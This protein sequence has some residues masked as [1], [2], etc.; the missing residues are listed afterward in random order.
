MCLSGEP[1]ARA[2]RIDYPGVFCQVACGGTCKRR[3]ETGSTNISVFAKKV[4]EPFRSNVVCRGKEMIEA[5][6]PGFFHHTRIRSPGCSHGITSLPWRRIGYGDKGRNKSRHH[7]GDYRFDRCSAAGF[8][9]SAGATAQ[10][11][12]NQSIDS[13]L[14]FDGGPIG[15]DPARRREIHK[16][17]G[18]ACPSTPYIDGN[19]RNLRHPERFYQ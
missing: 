15:D 2:L 5:D 8:A 4:S 3:I 6:V 18:Y 12:L 13:T 14:A 19:L 1:A 7:S 16:A 10:Q 9:V 17:P 11:P